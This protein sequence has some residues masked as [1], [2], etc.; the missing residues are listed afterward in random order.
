MLD[1]I[2]VQ[3]IARIEVVRGAARFYGTDALGGVINIVTKNLLKPAA[4]S[5]IYDRGS[6]GQLGIIWIAAL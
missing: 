6:T 5:V 4:A 3:N 1:R 2:N